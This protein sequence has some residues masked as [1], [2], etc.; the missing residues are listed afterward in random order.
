MQVDS[1]DNPTPVELSATA[2]PSVPWPGRLLLLTLNLIP[3][4]HLLAI[5]LILLKSTATW[6]W[7]IAAA[8]SLLYIAPPLAARLVLAFAPVSQGRIATGS[9]AFF[10][11]WAAFQLQVLFCRLIFLEELVRLMPGLYSA[12]LRL[13]G[14]RIGRLT[15]WSP[16][17]VITD[18]SFLRIGD[19]V[20]LAAGVRLNAHVLARNA[21]GEVE[22]LLADVTIGDR[23]IIGGYSLLTAGTVI[24]PDEATRAF[25]TSPPFSVWQNGKRARN[26]EPEAADHE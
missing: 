25:L 12:W 17:V 18:R 9:R 14:A 1:S 16:G 13:W 26:A 22:L 2:S 11:W 24:A 8:L 15:Y 3:A 10:S 19:D 21:A 7:R 4:L 23:A 6:P 5:T 20:V